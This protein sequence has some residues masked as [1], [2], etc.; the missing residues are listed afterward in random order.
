MNTKHQVNI[1]K[2]PSGKKM[3]LTREF[4]ADPATVWQ[5]YTDRNLLD[6][7]WAPKPWRA[8]TKSMDFREGGHWQYAMISPEGE[9]HWGKVIY[10][11][12]EP[13][14]SFVAN[15]MFCD[16]QGQ[17]NPGLPAMNWTNSFNATASGTRVTGTILFSNAEDMQ[18]I[19]EMGFQEGIAMAMNNL[20]ELFA[21]A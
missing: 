18:K 3:V 21:K 19:T 20:D 14:V 15:D 16:E 13:G 2:D 7:W 12:I 10:G 4:D 17:P 1:E 9:R 8:E 6:Q 5:A 11:K